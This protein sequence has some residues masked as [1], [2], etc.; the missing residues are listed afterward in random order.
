MIA[1]YYII[2]YLIINYIFN[3]IYDFTDAIN[4]ST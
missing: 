2:Y 1:I 3:S 4:L